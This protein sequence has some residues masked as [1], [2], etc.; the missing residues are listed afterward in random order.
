MSPS[1]RETARTD[2]ARTFKALSENQPDVMTAIE[3]EEK[4]WRAYRDAEA[5]LYEKLHPGARDAILVELAI[6]HVRAIEGM[7][8]R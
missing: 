5:D 2:L 6:E 3:T 1:D 8:E 4:A 7:V